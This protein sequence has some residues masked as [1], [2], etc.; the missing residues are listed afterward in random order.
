MNAVSPFIMP[1]RAGASNIFYSTVNIEKC[2][3][4]CKIDIEPNKIAEKVMYKILFKIKQIIKNDSLSD[5]DKVEEIVLV[6][7]EYNIDF[8]NCHDY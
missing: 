2:E 8:G 3:Q 1:N 6:F 7:E 4:L 5:F